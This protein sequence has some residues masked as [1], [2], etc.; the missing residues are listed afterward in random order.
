VS[1]VSIR[2]SQRQKVYDSERVAFEGG[3]EENYKPPEFKTV[4]EVQAYVDEVLASEAWKALGFSHLGM[5]RSHPLT[6]L[7]GRGSKRGRASSF[8]NTIKLPRFTRLRWYILHEL[9]HIATDYLHNFV[10]VEDDEDGG[11]WPGWENP[12]TGRVEAVTNVAAHGPEF[13]G[14]YLYLLRELLG[15]DIHDRLFSA[16][17]ERG[18]KV[19]PITPSMP[20]EEPEE[21]PVEEFRIDSEAAEAEPAEDVTDV[22]SHYCHNCG[23]ST[24]RGKF[25]SDACRYTY[26]NRRRHI[27]TTATWEK[28][29]EVCGEEFTATRVDTKTCSPAC[30]QRAYRQRRRAS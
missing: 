6:V 18:V 19:Q 7:D 13:V 12:E 23:L 15:G 9:A 2:D 26:H 1:T 28:V 3:I 30:R 25:C 14:I 5:F 11:G 4:A 8:S 24:G 17:A 16:F 10:Y 22:D 21:S 29:C 20:T 27:R